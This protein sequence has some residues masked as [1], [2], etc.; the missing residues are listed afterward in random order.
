[1]DQNLNFYQK[2][3]LEVSL[4]KKN[5]GPWAMEDIAFNKG[6]NNGLENT[7]WL[8]INIKKTIIFEKKIF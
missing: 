3:V 8:I 6:T 4:S 2:F 7:D 1:M 5:H